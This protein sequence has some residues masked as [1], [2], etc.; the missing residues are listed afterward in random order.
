[1]STNVLKIYKNELMALQQEDGYL[2]EDYYKFNDTLRL[3]YQFGL[4]NLRPLVYSAKGL[5][6]LWVAHDVNTPSQKYIALKLENEGA[7]ISSPMSQDDFEDVS[8]DTLKGV[9]DIVV[10]DLYV[11][12]V[13]STCMSKAK[14][15]AD[16]G[17]IVI[18]AGNDTS[19]NLY[20][21]GVSISSEPTHLAITSE[22]V[23][24]IT[25]TEPGESFGNLGTDPNIYMS[26]LQY[27]AKSLYYHSDMGVDAHMGFIYEPNNGYGGTH[28]HDQGGALSYFGYDW[29][30]VVF[31][32]QIS[33]YIEA[34]NSLN[35]FRYFKDQ[36]NGSTSNTG[37]HWLDVQAYDL[38]KAEILHSNN[39]EENL[40]YQKTVTGNAA[41]NNAGYAVDGYVTNSSQYAY[42]SS[43]PDNI[44]QLTIDMGDL[45]YANRIKLWHWFY[46][47]R[48]Y[49][50]PM[51]WISKDNKYWYN[52]YNYALEGTYTEKEIGKTFNLNNFD[53]INSPVD[54]GI[55][56]E[57]NFINLVDTDS[58]ALGLYL[59][60]Y[61][62]NGA[63]NVQS[64]YVN[65]EST[66][67][68]TTYVGWV[69]WDTGGGTT[70]SVR[71]ATT[72]T[73][74]NIETGQTYTV[75]LFL[76]VIEGTENLISSYNNIYVRQYDS[77]GSQVAEHG[78]AYNKEKLSNGWYRIWGSFTTT[79]NVDRLKIE[80]YD[81]SGEVRKMGFYGAQLVKEINSY[82]RVREFTKDIKRDSLAEIK[83]PGGF[84]YGTIIGRFIPR[85][86][87]VDG[88]PYTYT[89]TEHHS[90]LFRLQDDETTGG[91]FYRYYVNGAGAS[92]PF[93]DCDGSW[94]TSH[95]HMNYTIDANKE[96]E[97]IIERTTTSLTLRIYQESIYK[98]T[99]SVPLSSDKT[100]NRIIL[101]ANDIIWNG[102]HKD[103]TVY[104][105]FIYTDDYKKLFFNLKGNL[106]KSGDIFFDKIN[107]IGDNLWSLTELS[108]SITYGV[109]NGGTLV[110][111]NDEYGEYHELTVNGTYTFRGF[112]I[113]TENGE[114]YIFSGW[115][116]QSSDSNFGY[117][118]CAVEHEQ[119]GTETRG[120]N[121]ASAPKE[122]WFFGWSMSIAG[123]DGYLRC[124]IYPTV[125][126]S[127]S[128]TLK[129]RNMSLRKATPTEI[130]L[131][132]DGLF[133]VGEFSEYLTI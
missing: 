86:A 87:F 97:W 25:K 55:S 128:G 33:V 125:D 67:N 121:F 47:G 5:R 80:I 98:G 18:T 85:T 21:T 79:S 50:K 22:N 130:K 82:K 16:A 72:N 75:S 30:R 70:A 37:N 112:D 45:Y 93:L 91:T 28:V 107:E 132:N 81:Y 27:G 94:G 118:P 24:H 111:K 57:E 83:I 119:S 11:W 53:K 14:E 109:S 123:T 54:Y 95:Y 64:G 66:P 23:S 84:K 60:A 52:L 105:G 41:V 36:I 63:S 26:N 46:D 20:F 8:V 110:Y 9:Y 88:D 102:V 65:D 40:F 4:N 59:A 92:S 106:K 100:I 124:L 51:T 10:V 48:Y 114:P 77:N 2:Y 127:G 131:L 29:F 99:H 7:I 89:T 61:G 62:W 117:V 68:N 76:K 3:K 34:K 38:N 58:G 6:V 56:I 31:Y 96:I 104:D 15:C 49:Y 129:F 113:T 17:L 39:S 19:S 73:I 44:A 13:W 108:K 71:L 90:I 35:Y 43:A 78:Y 122:K 69:S 115:F 74:Y 120:V 101:G 116:W 32:Y 126:I 133:Q 1:M 42:I 103:I 12:M